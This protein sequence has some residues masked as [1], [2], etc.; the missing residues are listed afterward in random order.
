MVV[1]GE[2]NMPLAET[3]TREI[4]HSLDGQLAALTLGDC[5]AAVIV[6]ALGR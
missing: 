4:R 5:G 6:D 1:S 2:Q 3:A